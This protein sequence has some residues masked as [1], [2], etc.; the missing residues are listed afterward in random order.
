MFSAMRLVTVNQAILT[1]FNAI[2]LKF[3][4][5]LNKLGYKLE[6]LSSR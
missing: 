4:G 3:D 1:W 6:N 5:K 2:H